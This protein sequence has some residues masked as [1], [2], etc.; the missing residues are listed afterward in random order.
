MSR[1]SDFP[2]KY[3]LDGASVFGSPPI[4]HRRAFPS[5]RLLVWQGKGRR[6]RGGI[7]R[8]LKDFVNLS[9]SE[10]DATHTN[11]VHVCAREP[12]RPRTHFFQLTLKFM[13]VTKFPRQGATPDAIPS[14][15]TGLLSPC[16]INR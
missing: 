13:A 4:P 5:L 14:K 9:Q 15:L 3:P 2:V 8:L 12:V 6:P 1:A 7:R 11:P 16:M 10:T